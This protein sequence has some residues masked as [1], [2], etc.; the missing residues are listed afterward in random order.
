MHSVLESLNRLF[1]N[2]SEFSINLESLSKSLRASVP[3][4]DMCLS[5][6]WGPQGPAIR[7][8]RQTEGKLSNSVAMEELPKTFSE[9]AMV[10]IKLGVTYLWIDALCK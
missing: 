1:Q 9:A 3:V 7:L 2:G 8:T 4:Q 6:C 10:C 5:H